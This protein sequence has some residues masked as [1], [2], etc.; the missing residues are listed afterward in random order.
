MNNSE[1]HELAI[2]DNLL[3]Q[4]KG[5]VREERLVSLRAIALKVGA[6]RQIVP[7]TLK[8]AFASLAAGTVAAGA[9]IEIETIPPRVHCRD[10]GKEEEGFLAACPSCQSIGIDLIAGR[11]LFIDYI[12][13]D[14]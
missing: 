12:E 9:K 1:M 7:E 4:V 10:C 3:R 2:A 6:L 14:R 11:E 5:I 13:G 8:E